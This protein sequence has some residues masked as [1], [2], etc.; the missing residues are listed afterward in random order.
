MHGLQRTRGLGGQGTAPDVRGDCNDRARH[1]TATRPWPS[2]GGLSR[3]RRCQ[4]SWILMT[5]Q[6]MGSTSDLRCFVA[7]ARA[8][9][10]ICPPPVEILIIDFPRNYLQVVKPTTVDIHMPSRD[11]CDCEP[12]VLAPRPG[13]SLPFYSARSA[14]S[15]P[16]DKAPAHA[17]R[18]PVSPRW[19][20]LAGRLLAVSA[21]GEPRALWFTA[22]YGP[23]GGGPEKQ[24][25]AARADS[26]RQLRVQCASRGGATG[27]A[28]G[29]L[30]W[31][32]LD[33]CGK[34]ELSEQESI[35]LALV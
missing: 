11:R 17:A 28:S 29:I 1:S 2:C 9:F 33:Q 24:R 26:L 21:G 4:I 14:R 27:K 5:A 25:A 12:C 15:A 31:K 22:Q 7:L 18:V 32:S 19:P 16:E 20:P 6:S 34:L 30:E 13:A 10:V 23:D 35:T 3:N 8:L